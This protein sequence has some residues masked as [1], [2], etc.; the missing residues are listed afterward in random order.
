MNNHK[1]GYRSVLP[2]YNGWTVLYDCVLATIT[3]TV[4]GISCS[5]E[6]NTHVKDGGKGTK[7]EVNSCTK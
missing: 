6:E 7:Q 2:Y 5:S 4:E 3:C 1:T